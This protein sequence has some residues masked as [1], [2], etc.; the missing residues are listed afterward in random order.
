MNRPVWM[1]VW[2]FLAAGAQPAMAV[3]KPAP[4]AA[5]A[6]AGGATMWSGMLPWVVGLAVLAIVFGW[7][8]SRSGGRK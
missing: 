6:A 2:V 5:P 3:S 8:R 4:G 1:A 7:W